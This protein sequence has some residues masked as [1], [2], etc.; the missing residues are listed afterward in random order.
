MLSVWRAAVNEMQSGR[1][2]VLATIL[3]VVGSSPRHVGTRFLIRSDGSIVG[4]IGGGLF[5]AQV[6]EMAQSALEAG[7]SRRARFSFYGKDAQSVDMICGG[8][9]EVLIE[10]VDSRNEARGAIFRKIV[11]MIEQRDSGCLLTRLAIPPDGQTTGPMEHVLVDGD[12]QLVGGFP[13]DAEAVKAIPPLRLMKPAQF[14]EVSGAEH[15]ILLESLHPTGVL[16]IFGGGHVGV[17]VAHLAA[18]VNFRV[19]V[20]DDRSAFLSR[21]HVPDA[22]DVVT[23]DSFANALQGIRVDEDSYVVIVT[24]GHSHD[25]TVLAQALRTNAGYVGMIGSRR[26]NALIF[27]SLLE[28]GFTREDLARVHAPIGLP[29]GGETPEEIGV[30]II[31]EMIQVRHRKN[32]LQHLGAAC[33]AAGE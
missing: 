1:N 11:A 9:A 21:E 17:C 2:V 12:G 10:F 32:R 4:T 26:K 22:D 5:E 7:I 18:Y 19:V 28:Q 8:K 27:E 13:G 16:Y 24:R 29:I 15:P 33:P 14:L 20:L 23:L 3:S 6:Q 31:A 30:S 25:R